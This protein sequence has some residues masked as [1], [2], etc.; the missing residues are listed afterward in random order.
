[1]SRGEAKRVAMLLRWQSDS[2]EV[3]RGLAVSLEKKETQ[4]LAVHAC[5][6]AHDCRQERDV[7]VVIVL[8]LV[9]VDLAQRIP[10]LR[11]SRPY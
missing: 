1:M 5:G 3:R 9:V 4:E 11:Q 10:R 6:C 7:L 2:G 8:L